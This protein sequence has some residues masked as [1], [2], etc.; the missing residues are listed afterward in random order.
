LRETA[1]ISKSELARR[2]GK[3]GKEVRRVLNPKQPT[4]LLVLTVALR[5]LGKRL[6]RGN[7]ADTL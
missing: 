4:K 2:I 5:A 6:G 7:G 3:D 1:G